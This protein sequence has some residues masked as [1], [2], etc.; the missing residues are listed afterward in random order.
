MDTNLIQQHL[1]LELCEQIAEEWAKGLYQS[2]KLKEGLI[3]FILSL[4]SMPLPSEE[5]VISWAEKAVDERLGLSRSTRLEIYEL[6]RIKRLFVDKV[7][8]T[9]TDAFVTG[10][11][12]LDWL[13][14][15]N[16]TFDKVTDVF[17]G[18]F[19]THSDRILSG[20]QELISELSSPII[21]VAPKVGILPLIGDIDTH[22][23]KAIL[24]HSLQ[25]SLKKM[26]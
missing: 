17:L 2:D 21:E 26:S 12:F 22:R 18:T 11:A 4:R 6:N 20:Q 24:T 13:I 8:E 16:R 5:K 9:L 10:P 25:D 3:E 23:A 14:G 1:T 19:E 15:V 7:K